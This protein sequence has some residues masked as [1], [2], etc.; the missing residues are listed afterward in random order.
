[1]TRER[2]APAW[3]LSEDS[4]WP[5]HDSDQIRELKLWGGGRGK[6]GVRGA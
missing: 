4:S 1:L 6:R 5:R 3:G 2:T